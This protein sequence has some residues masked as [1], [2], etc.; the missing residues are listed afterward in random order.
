MQI[1]FVS[2][3]DG[4]HGGD[5]ERLGTDVL[6]SDDDVL[7]TGVL[8]R[9]GRR[10]LGLVEAPREAAFAAMERI[11]TH[12]DVSTLC[13]LREQRAPDLETGKA[14]PEPVC[15]EVRQSAARLDLA[16]ALF[17]LKLST[18]LRAFAIDDASEPDTDAWVQSDET[19]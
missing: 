1:A 7:V 9:L 3:F 2:D 19:G 8:L 4:D 11:S 17:A 15:E 18:G 10:F 6:Q 16:S 12:P 13:V 14:F 5:L